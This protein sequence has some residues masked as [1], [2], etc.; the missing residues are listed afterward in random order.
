MTTI[1]NMSRRDV[2]QGVAGMTGLVL[3]F[4]VAGWRGIPFAEAATTTS[5]APNVYLAI[6]TA[7]LGG[8]FR[9]LLR[10]RPDGGAERGGAVRRR[11]LRNVGAHPEPAGCPH[12]AP[13]CWAC[14]RRT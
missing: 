7:N 5:F 1:V 10:A 14:R 3:G 4:H 2:V 8:L 12:D 11:Y 13:R 9:P 6:G